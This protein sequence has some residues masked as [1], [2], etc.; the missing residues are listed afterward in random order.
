MYSSLSKKTPIILS[1]LI[2]TSAGFL[3]KFYS[4]PAKHW[5]NNYFA[6]VLYE[7]FWCLVLLFFW[8]N[9]KYI[10]RIAI[11][12]FSFTS[13]LEILQLWHPWILQ[14]IRFTFIGRTLIG[15]TFSWWDFPHY[16]LGCIIGWFWMRKI[17]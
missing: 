15:T 11:E 3:F 4:G 17:L 6:G 10:T 14:Q 9:K 5:F 16:I 12:V 7:I 2:V 13:L 1:L 8:P